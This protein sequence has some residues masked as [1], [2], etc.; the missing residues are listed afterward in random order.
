[1]AAA[2]AET[3]KRHI[4]RNAGIECHGKICFP[5]NFA[6]YWENDCGSTKSVCQANDCGGKKLLKIIY[7]YF[8]IF[9]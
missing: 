4:G 3:T 5:T 1:M 8:L 6:E 2:R 7:I 9:L